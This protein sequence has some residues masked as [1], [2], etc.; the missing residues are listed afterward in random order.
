MAKFFDALTP[1]HLDFIARLARAGNIQCI[2]RSLGSYR[3]HPDSA[4]AR[5]RARVNMYARFVRRRLAERDAGRDVTWS[6][7]ELAYRP[8]WRERRRDAIEFWYRSAALWRSEGRP[9]RALRCAALAALAAPL[10]TFRRFYRQRIKTRR[11]V[12]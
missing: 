6:D 10:Y 12:S 7:F 11:L 1:A 4:M 8:T 2:P 5:S 9:L 3:I